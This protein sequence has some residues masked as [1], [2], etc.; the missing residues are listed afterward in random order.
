MGTKGI[1]AVRFG[2]NMGCHGTGFL[3]ITK[4]DKQTE[5]KCPC[6]QYANFNEKAERLETWNTMKRKGWKL[7]K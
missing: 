3:P 5:A 2:C 6:G 7:V 4:G 1:D